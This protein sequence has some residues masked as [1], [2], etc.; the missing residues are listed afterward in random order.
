MK[1][2]KITALYERLSRED[3][4]NQESNSIATQKRI[5][6]TYAEQNGLTPCR[7]FSDDGYSGKDFLRPAFREMLTEIEQG[8][9]GTVIVKELDR[10]GRAY[11]ESGLYR[12]MFRKM[13]VRFISIAEGH[14]SDRGED[15]FTP[16]REVINEFYLHQYSKKIK[17]A[18]RARGMAGKHTSSY[19]PY[20]YL[21][22]PEDKN[23]W[24]V[25]TE[26]A[27]IV[28]RIFWLTIDGKG[29][30]QI[31]KILEADK[32]EIPG[33]YLAKKGVGLH[34]R[35]V[36]ENPCHWSSST[37]CAIL[38][39]REYLGH[40]VNFKSTKDSYKDKKNHY[41]P[42]SEWVIFENTHEAIIDQT[43][44]D[45]V[46][47]IRGNVK[48]RPD[49]WGYVHPLTGL[50]R[51]AG[52][53]GK[54]YVHR[55][56]NGKDCPQYVCG[57]YG[58]IPV[59]SKCKSA[60]RINA[61]AL[62]SLITKTLKEIAAYAKED[63]ATFSKTVQ[64]SL[65]AKQT[66][67]AGAQKKRLAVMKNRRAELEILFGKIYEDNALG[68][69]S[70][71]QFTTLAEQY[72]R[73]LEQIDKAIPELQST[74]KRYDDGRGRA[75]KFL[76]LLKRYGDF[77]ELTTPMLNEF[78]EK[79]IVHERDRKGSSDTSQT[80]DIHFNF[81]GTFTVP[82]APIDP[83]T[84]AAQE[85]ER[86]KIEER[87]DRLHRNYL[88]RKASGKQKEYERRYEQRRKERYAE[89]K[90]AAYEAVYGNM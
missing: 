16:F 32:I 15:D 34:Q 57:N 82:G 71:K 49:G 36:F 76:E 85:E 84:L 78:V 20:G 40:T 61:E 33:A 6:E 2:I 30:Y 31:S 38:K 77:H 12:E 58:K 13:G 80:V 4:D 62:L 55:I 70:D 45:N 27:A 35:H 41:V 64:E 47:R 51:C 81:I 89:R 1:Q 42:E 44:F 90:A 67:E 69:L 28:R 9:I 14:D 46:Q 5:L 23:Q 25:D 87:K 53:G 26:A 24:V 83:A 66:A 52:C 37:I 74:V 43:T 60:H 75:T 65:A 79:I 54:L 22:S 19:P 10:F 17:A 39:K 50:V 73:E 11:L 56:V 72:E 48:R 86:R 29:P 59:G 7:H 21:K 63:V 18:F 8:N 3:G 68:K 88:K